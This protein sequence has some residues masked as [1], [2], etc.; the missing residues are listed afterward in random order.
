MEVGFMD[1]S[2]KKVEIGKDKVSQ[3]EKRSSNSEGSSSSENKNPV[4]EDSQLS[5]GVEVELNADNLGIHSNH[6]KVDNHLGKIRL[7]EDQGDVGAGYESLAADTVNS[8]E[9]NKGSK[10]VNENKLRLI[11]LNS[12]LK[13][14]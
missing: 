2:T 10:V 5:R 8:I 12:C 6:G 14:K 3:K 11:G 7:Q 9:K 4:N 1:N 13:V